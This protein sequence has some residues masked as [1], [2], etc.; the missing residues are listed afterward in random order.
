MEKFARIKARHKDTIAELNFW[1]NCNAN[2]SFASAFFT[3]APGLVCSVL[4]RH[5]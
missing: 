2:A 1:H 4:G 5:P 3:N